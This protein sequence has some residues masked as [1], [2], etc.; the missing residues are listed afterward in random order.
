[1]AITNVFTLCSVN[2]NRVT[3]VLLG[4]MVD[5][6]INLGISRFLEGSDGEVDN[7]YVSINEQRPMIGF[8]TTALAVALGVAGISGTPL[9]VDTP[10]TKGSLEAF[11]Q[12]LV[13]GGTR[14]A[15]ATMLTINEGILIPRTLSAS[16]GAVARLSLEAHATYDGTND[17]IV[18]LAAQTIP[19]VTPGVAELFTLGPV[20]LNGVAVNGV[21]DLSIDFGIELIVEG[22]DG[23]VW[24]RFVAIMRRSPTISFTTPDAGILTT[25][26]ITGDAQG[27]TDSV[28]YFR[29][30]AEGGTRELDATAEHIKISIDDGMVHVEDLSAS[31]GARHGVRCTLIPTWD[32]TA[33]VMVI[34]PASAIT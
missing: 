33:A 7:R 16:Q 27:A 12:L 11:L 26:G 29:K 20:Q 6:N 3:D 13:E 23:E 8:T 24:P 21:V 19:T 5:Q 22:S 31:H 30:I 15:T 17:P 4:Q 28:V 10:A 32:G 9:D 34:D 14:A 18:I 25:L 2:L 1:M